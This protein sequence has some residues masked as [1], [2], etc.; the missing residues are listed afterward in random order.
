MSGRAARRGFDLLAKGGKLVIVGLF[1]GELTV[2]L[3]SIPM[4]AVTIQGSYVGS[5]QELKDLINRA[6]V[7]RIPITTRPQAE[8]SAALEDLRAGRAVGR[9]VLV[10]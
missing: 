6:K 8:A 3:P 7:A 10:P 4:R 9:Y 2:P 1:G 5:L